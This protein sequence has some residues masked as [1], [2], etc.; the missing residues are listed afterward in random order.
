MLREV[1]KNLDYKNK[2]MVISHL[3]SGLQELKVFPFLEIL[4]AG[5]EM[6][7]GFKEMSLVVGAL[8]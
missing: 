2:K 5:I 6:S 3:W 8:L 1:I 4:M 7:F